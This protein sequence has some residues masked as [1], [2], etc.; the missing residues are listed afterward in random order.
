[1]LI[2]VRQSGLQLFNTVPVCSLVGDPYNTQS[3]GQVLIQ[4]S[5]Q[6]IISTATASDT[7][8]AFLS[9]TD[10]ATTG[11]EAFWTLSNVFI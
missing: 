10:Y 3:P 11:G 2:Q 7:Q 5:Q 9:K 8:H 1:M 4:T 6:T